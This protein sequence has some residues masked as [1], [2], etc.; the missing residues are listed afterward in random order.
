MQNLYYYSSILDTVLFTYFMDLRLTNYN[1]MYKNLRTI[2]WIINSRCNLKCLHCYT[3]SIQGEELRPNYSKKDIALMAK[4]IGSVEPEVIYISGGE[5]LIDKDLPIFLKEAR[6]IASKSLCLCTNGMLISDKLVEILKKN[7]VNGVSLSLRH[8]DPLKESKISQSKEVHGRVLEAIKKLKLAGIDVAL[9]MTI[10][11]SNCDSIDDFIDLCV[12][13]NV[14]TMIFKRFRPIGRGEENNFALS[15]IKNKQVLHH[16]FLKSKQNPNL[17]IKVHDPLY[18]L[19]FYEHLKNNKTKDESP[20]SG[21]DCCSSMK[22]GGDDY[23]GC[24]A[25]IEWVGIDPLGNVSP[26][27]LLLYTGLI[28]GNIREKSLKEIMEKSPEIKALENGH[29]NGRCP[30]SNICGGCRSHAAATG[31]GYLSKDPMCLQ[32]CKECF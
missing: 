5:P 13:N 31:K 12:H 10:M 26:C 19:E 11:K 3:K 14:S 17:N 8:P 27:P 15:K 4:N 24:N 28:I 6:K 29:E 7:G 20:L 18:S 30:K 32:K 9:E 21:F 2:S 23:W 25:G 1:Q 16:I 22:I